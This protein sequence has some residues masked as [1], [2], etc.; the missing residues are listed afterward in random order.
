MN[1][2]NTISLEYI[3]ILREAGFN[4]LINQP[5]RIVKDEN[6]N[7]VSCST[8]DHIITNSSQNFTKTGIL[9]SDVS[10]RL[11]IFGLLNCNPSGI[12]KGPIYNPFFPESKKGTFPGRVN[13]PT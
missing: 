1:K 12:N 2:S 5:T 7:Y 4:A 6:F 8:I 9:V 10:D 13:K 11:P 3:D